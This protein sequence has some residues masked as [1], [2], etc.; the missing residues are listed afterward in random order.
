MAPAVTYYVVL[1]KQS[2]GV[3]SALRPVSRLLQEEEDVVR[4]RLLVQT[5]VVLRRFAKKAN[6][7]GMLNQL[8][9][10]G[11]EAFLVSDN[12]LRSHLILYAATASKGTGGMA[13]RDFADKPLFCPFPDVVRVLRMDLPTESGGSTVVIDLLRRNSNVTPR[14][15]TALFDIPQMLGLERAGPDEL[16]AA[17]GEATGVAVDDSFNHHRAEAEALAQ[18]FGALPAEFSP[19]EAML[20]EPYIP[21]VARAANLFSFLAQ[22]QLTA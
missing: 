20:V 8:N 10:L 3:G 2:P 15:D 9:A 11:L 12:A 17:I 14:I 18:D 22:A 1:P 16:L 6:A 7:E 13:F 5:F 19:P 21:A 4:G